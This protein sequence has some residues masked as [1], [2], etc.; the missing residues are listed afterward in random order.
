ML[1]AQHAKDPD[2]AVALAM[3]GADLSRARADFFRVTG[4]IL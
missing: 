1:A 4:T 2:H 3:I